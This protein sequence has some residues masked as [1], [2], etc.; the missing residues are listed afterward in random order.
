MLSLVIILWEN[1]FYSPG[2]SAI[3][4]FYFQ[5]LTGE[6]C[7]WRTNNWLKLTIFE[8]R[9]M[10]E[11]GKNIIIPNCFTIIFVISRS[12]YFILRGERFIIIICCLSFF[13]NRQERKEGDDKEWKLSPLVYSCEMWDG[14]LLS[15]GG[16]LAGTLD[17]TLHNI[18]YIS[19]SYQHTPR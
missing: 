14:V 12:I 7:I 19:F 17:R 9:I 4:R 1:L 15:S 2:R 8:V 3:F 13:S 18:C 6:T 16:L 10:V 5:P 11:N